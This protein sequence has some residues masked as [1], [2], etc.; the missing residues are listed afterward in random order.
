MNFKKKSSKSNWE[1]LKNIENKKLLI[2]SGA[3]NIKNLEEAIKTSNIK[4]VD[5]SSSLESSPGEK[6]IKKINNFL[7]L[8]DKL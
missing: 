6:N 8:A 2:L 4:F 7:N 5:V 3:I 1:L